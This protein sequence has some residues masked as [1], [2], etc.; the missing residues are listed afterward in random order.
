MIRNASSVIIWIKASP[1]QQKC[2]ISSKRPS[3]IEKAADDQ[4][5]AAQQ[6]QK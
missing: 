4:E 5:K 2:N 1:D 3:G 6:K